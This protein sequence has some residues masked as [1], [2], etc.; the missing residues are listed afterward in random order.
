MKQKRALVTNVAL[1]MG[2]FLVGCASPIDEAS[3]L[4]TA[5]SAVEDRQ[6]ADIPREGV[7]V[8]DPEENEAQVG[9]ERGLGPY[10]TGGELRDPRDRGPYDPDVGEPPLDEAPYGEEPY[11][12]DIGRERPIDRVGPD[13]GEEPEE[14]PSA[15]GVEGKLPMDEG[16]V[17]DEPLEDGAEETDEGPTGSVETEIRRYPRHRHGQPHWG[18]GRHGRWRHPRWGHHFPHWRWGYPHRRFPH[19]HHHHPGWGW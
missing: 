7:D 18:W 16:E 19:R 11:G 12:P 2:L 17:Q 4:G 1:G 3:R 13:L 8:N 9:T 15:P 5:A 14:G 10:G 6:Q